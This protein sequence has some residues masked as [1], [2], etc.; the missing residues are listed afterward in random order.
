MKQEIRPTISSIDFDTINDKKEVETLL[1][2]NRILI[3]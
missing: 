2:T 3:I 1:N